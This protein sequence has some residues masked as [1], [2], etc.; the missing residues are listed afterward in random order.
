[1]PLF[2]GENSRGIGRRREKGR[3]EN[4]HPNESLHI[5]R[6]TTQQGSNGAAKISYCAEKARGGGIKEGLWSGLQAW[7]RTKESP[8]GSKKGRW[9]K[10]IWQISD[11]VRKREKAAGEASPIDFHYIKKNEVIWTYG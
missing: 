6:K 3:Q 5:K 4:A 11:W 1:M 10:N 9:G 7:S 2:Y 8:S